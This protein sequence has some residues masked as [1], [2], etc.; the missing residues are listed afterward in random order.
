MPPYLFVLCFSHGVITFIFVTRNSI[1]GIKQMEVCE[2]NCVVVLLT[3][4]LD[5]KGTNKM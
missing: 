2:R 1:H 5:N 3:R 4:D